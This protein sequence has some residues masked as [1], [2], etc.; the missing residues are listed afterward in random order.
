MIRFVVIALLLVLPV[1]ALAEDRLPMPNYQRQPSDPA[2]LAQ[3]VQL[4]GHLGPSV[5]AGAHVEGGRV[6]NLAFSTFFGRKMDCR[7]MTVD[8]HG[9]VYLAGST[10]DAGCPTTEGAYER[11]FHGEA[12]MAISKW[13]PEGKL[14]WSTLVGSPGHD[15][16]YSVKVDSQGCVYAAGIG[17]GRDA[18]LAR[19]LPTE[20][21]GPHE[22][23]NTCKA[24]LVPG[25][26]RARYL[27]P[28]GFA[29]DTTR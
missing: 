4:H 21:A 10:W 29:A 3:V 12:D 19:R 24:G 28:Q 11:K 5:V 14:L 27:S 25:Q 13:S 23:P 15:R 26:V 8:A 17:G 9:N 20:T 18:R 22:Y 16:P 1:L 6:Y 2:W 7:G